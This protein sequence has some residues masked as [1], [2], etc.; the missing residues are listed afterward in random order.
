LYVFDNDTPQIAGFEIHEDLQQGKSTGSVQVKT[1]YV[2]VDNINQHV[3]RNF[4]ETNII[5]E[6]N[7]LMNMHKSCFYVHT[8]HFLL[9]NIYYLHK[10]MRAHTR[11]CTRTTH[12]HTHIHTVQNYINILKNNLKPFYYKRT[13]IQWMNTCPMCRHPEREYYGKVWHWQTNYYYI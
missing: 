4:N 5:Q 13:F 9:I 8:I 7:W 6:E 11:A 2:Y 12:T 1:I 10:Q 3:L